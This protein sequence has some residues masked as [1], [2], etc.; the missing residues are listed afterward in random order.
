MKFK[1]V[2]FDMDGLMLDSERVYREIFNRAAADCAVACPDELHER[3]LGRNS[4]DTRAILL[5]EWKDEALLAKFFDR[6]QHHHELCFTATPPA[7]KTGLHELLDFLE[8]RNVPKVVA[9]STRRSHAIDRLENSGL[10][11][12]FKTITTGDQVERG[13]PAPDIFL[14]AAGT[15]GIQPSD[16]VVL[17]D[18]EAGVT[19]AH[20]AGMTP[21]MVPDMKQPCDAVRDIAHSVVESLHHVRELLAKH[22]D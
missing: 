15:I 3:M 2:I 17:E 16:C 20:A 9:T 7:I 5:D 21:I 12:R 19:G 22:L 8:E 13:K 11:R 1:A 18:S 10:L 14:M 4:V 6:A